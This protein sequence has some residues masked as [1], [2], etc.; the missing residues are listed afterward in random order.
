MQAQREAAEKKR[1]ENAAAYVQQQ[2]YVPEKYKQKYG[3]SPG[4]AA[5]MGVGGGYR[6]GTPTAAGAPR[7]AMAGQGPPPTGH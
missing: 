7:G 3:V 4:M 2:K 5:A 1:K 6:A